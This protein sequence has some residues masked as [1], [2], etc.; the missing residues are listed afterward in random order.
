MNEWKQAWVNKPVPR[1][2]PPVRGKIRSAQVQFLPTA[3]RWS[4]RKMLCKPYLHKRLN[5]IFKAFSTTR[6]SPTNQP[7]RCPCDHLESKKNLLISFLF[8]LSFLLVFLS[9]FPLFPS[10]PFSL[11]RFPSLPPSLF[12]QIQQQKEMYSFCYYGALG[13]LS[14]VCQRDGRLLTCRHF[15][16]L[17]LLQDHS[18]MDSLTSLWP[19]LGN[20]HHHS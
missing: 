5:R 15:K 7:I 14:S 20:F 18:H 8:L 16:M 3:K 17:D 1:N 10:F 12:F 4:E 13:P 11:L 9:S 2:G 6:I 19:F